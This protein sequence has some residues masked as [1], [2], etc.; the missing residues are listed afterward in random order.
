MK[1]KDSLFRLIKSLTKTE[2][3]FFKIYSSRHVIGEQNNYVELFDAIDSQKN[4]NEEALLKKFADKKFANR[5]PVAKSYLYDLV[6]RSMNVY[7]NQNTI[8]AQ[9]RE[10]MGSVEFLYQKGIYDHAFKLVQKAKKIAQDAEKPAL[11]LMAYEWEKQLLEAL[12]FTTH[13]DA[14]LLRLFEN[15]QRLLQQLTEINQYWL[16]HTQLLYHNAQQGITANATDL[17]K[18]TQ[19]LTHPLLGH[20]N[21][22]Q[23]Y[24]AALLRYK[25]LATCFFIMRQLQPCYEY[26]RKLVL[27]LES[28]PE[29]LPQEAIT[30]INAINNLLNTT[31]AL[32][33]QE[34]RGFYLSKLQA[35]LTHDKW[36]TSEALQLKLFEAYY[37]HQMTLYIGNGNYTDGLVCLTKLE[38]GL[39]RFADRIDGIG[40]IMLCYYAFHI[41]F[42]AGQFVQAHAWLMRVLEYQH[43][44]LRRD[45]V[46]FAKIL[47]LLT[48]YEMRNAPVFAKTAKSV[49]RFLLGKEKQYELENIIVRFLKTIAQLP[50]NADT[51][52][53]FYQLR[54]TLAALNNDAY[55]KRVF[56]YFDFMAWVN[57]KLSPV[58]VSSLQQV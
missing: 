17:D 4:Y 9:L 16:L 52:P 6:L 12:V 47:T 13:T 10:L 43:T 44:N 23:S 33:K 7:H 42:G 39:T 30:Y 32:Q 18:I 37:Y 55:E 26:S 1:K 57:A 51:M 27:L 41:C 28:R 15:N 36:Q 31:A 24:Q 48:T 40:V 38:E 53:V 56:A 34:E 35:M 29:L 19:L 46:T 25:T 54:Q 3:R 58:P 11:L 45:I 22:P 49:Y 5:L 14:D 21:E 20:G 8:E 2:K 50:P